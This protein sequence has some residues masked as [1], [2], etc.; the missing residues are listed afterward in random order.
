MKMAV[1][2]LL[3]LAIISAFG[4]DGALAQSVWTKYAYNPVLTNGPPG[5]WNRHVFSPCVLFNDDNGRFEMWFSAVV[6]SPW[7]PNSIGYATSADGVSW[8][9]HPDPVLT[10]G[11]AGSWD[12]GAGVSFQ[13][14]I[15]EDGT[16]KMWYCGARWQGDPAK[17]GYATSVDGINWVKYAGNPVMATGT[18]D[19]EAGGFGGCAIMSVPGGYRMWYAGLNAARS[20]NKIGYATSVDG[21][22]WVRDDAN[23][24]ILDI[25]PVGQWDDG[26]VAACEVLRLGGQYYLWY[27][28]ARSGSAYYSTGLA[29]SVDGVTNWMRDPL[30]P[31]LTTAPATWDA[32]YVAGTA[33]VLR[34][35]TLYMWYEGARSPIATYLYRIGLATSSPV[36]HVDE[37]GPGTP[38]GFLV[39]QNY[40]NPF[41]PSTTIEYAL[42]ER[43]FVEIEVFDVLGRKVAALLKEEKPAGTHDIRW[44]ADGMA[45]GAYF[46][47]IRAGTFSVTRQMTLVK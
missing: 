23:N 1:S 39:R 35:N 20:A 31:V 36:A 12:S 42:P 13:R 14:V 33:A 16:Y 37:G 21:I 5:A 47:R 41:N 18:A 43:A 15:R 27:A 40:P 22:T 4:S 11:E 9:M 19:W 26:S 3:W 6:G 28:G 7:Y 30:N 46:C 45:S 24:P 17:I 25:G 38:P 2:I 8:T 10:G 29:V 44:D 32:N 34:G